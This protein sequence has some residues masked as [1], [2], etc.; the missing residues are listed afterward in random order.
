V[1]RAVTAVGL[2]YRLSKNK[3][4]FDSSELR[5]TEC[6]ATSLKGHC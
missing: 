3:G 2:S 5:V 6:F 1:P 4:K